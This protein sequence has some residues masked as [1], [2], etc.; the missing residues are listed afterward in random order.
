MLNV[1]DRFISMVNTRDTIR[2]SSQELFIK[3][4]HI[5]NADHSLKVANEAQKVARLFGQNEEKASCAAYLHDISEIIPDHEMVS[6]AN[7]LPIK[8]FDEE[9]K[10][11][12]ILHQK[13]SK[14]IANQ[15][16]A[17]NDDE[18]LNAIECHTTLKQQPSTMDMI[19]FISDKMSWDSKYNETFIQDVRKGFDKSLEHACYAY[20]K[21]LYDNRASLKVLHPWTS[22][23]YHY[24]HQKCTEF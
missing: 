18:I 5:Q 8:I 9:I 20:V 7:A 11:P 17:I 4:G 10:F 21:F 19:L 12:M 16:F 14:A 15:V 23:A 22:D 3:Y 13:L 1:F 2:T 24:L 6:H